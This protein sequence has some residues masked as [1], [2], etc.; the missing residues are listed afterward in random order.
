[1]NAYSLTDITHGYDGATVLTIPGLEIPAGNITALVGENGSGKTTLLHL[2]ALLTSPDRG[3]IQLFG[4]P[5]SRGSRAR[6]RQDVSLLLQA[7]Y[8]FR[9]SVAENVAW[10]LKGMNLTRSERARRMEEALEWVGLER[11]AMRPARQLSGGEGQRLALARLLARQPKVI[12]LDEPTNHVDDATTA[13][14]EDVL[15]GWVREHATTV[16]LATHDVNQAVRLNAECLTLAGGC[17]RE[18]AERV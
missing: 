15:T 17:I 6:M 18:V 8:L 7:P 10:G 14:I 5:V 11:F 12:L 16:V 9:S 13:R 2:L 3:R 4:Q 1:M